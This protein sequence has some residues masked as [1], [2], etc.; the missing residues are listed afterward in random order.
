MHLRRRNQ[1][2]VG[3]NRLHGS[4]R[5]EVGSHHHLSPIAIERGVKGG[6]AIVR[7]IENEIEHHEPRAGGEEPVEEQ[8]PNFARPRKRPLTHEL[9]RAVARQF[10]WFEGRQ[11][12]RALIDP[13]KDEVVAGRRLAALALR[14][15]LRSVSRPTRRRKRKADPGRNAA[16]ARAPSRRERSRR[17]SAADGARAN[18][19]GDNRKASLAGQFQISSD[20]G[21][22][23]QQ[24]VWPVLWSRA[25][26]LLF[27]RPVLPRK[28]AEKRFEQLR[29]RLTIAPPLRWSRRNSLSTWSWLA[30]AGRISE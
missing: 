2:V 12:Q 18:A 19:R 15:N 9:K 4:G 6:I 16:E 25:S 11:L 22:P 28:L 10:A 8:G 27:E 23:R 7:R 5:V 29:F 30:R 24:V 26:R 13:E 3:H 21:L 17:E 14:E 1:N 20:A